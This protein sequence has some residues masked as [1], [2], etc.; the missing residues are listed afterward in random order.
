MEIT[1]KCFFCDGT[2]NFQVADWEESRMVWC[3]CNECNG[4][5]TITKIIEHE[6]EEED[7][8]F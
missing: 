3:E 6:D 8:V 2:G 4:E 5:G 1:T 7:F